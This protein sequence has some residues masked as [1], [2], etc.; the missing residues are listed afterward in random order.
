MQLDG[1]GS[2]YVNGKSVRIEALDATI[3]PVLAMHGG[4]GQNA[5]AS[6]MAGFGAPPQQDLYMRTPYYDRVTGQYK[7]PEFKLLEIPH[8]LKYEGCWSPFPNCS[9]MRD[10]YRDAAGKAFDCGLCG[11]TCR[12]NPSQCAPIVLKSTDCWDR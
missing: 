9:N 7:R 4:A 8:R 3:A 5:A 11:T 6:L 1:A 2:V 12:P 10:V